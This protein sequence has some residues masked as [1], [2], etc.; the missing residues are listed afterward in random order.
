M[1]KEVGNPLFTKCGSN[2]FSQLIESYWVKYG[3]IPKNE[4]IGIYP[5]NLNKACKNPYM[6]TC[7]DVN[8]FQSLMQFL[9]KIFRR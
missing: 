3:E 4:R 1:K 2:K 7:S 5:R 6:N 8:S 9:F